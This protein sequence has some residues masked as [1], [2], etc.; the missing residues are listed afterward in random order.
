MTIRG[1]LADDQD[2]VRAGFRMIL[3]TQS[4]IE[5]IGDHRSR[6]P[7]SQQRLLPAGDSTI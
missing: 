1:L 3:E 7:Y 6:R 4:D 5:V 2:L